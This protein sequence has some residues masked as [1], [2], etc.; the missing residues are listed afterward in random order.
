MRN[1]LSNNWWMIAIKGVLILT[2]GVV[3]LVI[4]A[5]TILVLTTW[6]GI[7]LL[8]AGLLTFLILASNWKRMARGKL[9]LLLDGLLD[10]G[11]GLLILFNPEQTVWVLT[12]L[13]GVWLLLMG[14]IQIVYALRTRGYLKLWW[15]AL[16]NGLV[17]AV[18]GGL[19]WSNPLEGLLALTVLFGLA[20][21]FYGVLL[22]VFSL[23]LRRKEPT[24]AK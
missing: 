18:L 8:L 9:W 15:V 20:T 1:T 6:I 5:K 13:I 3:A 12:V 2:L 4:P 19:I 17:T 11:I 10:T 21:C 22:I 14:I 16:I 24:V 23:R 7:F